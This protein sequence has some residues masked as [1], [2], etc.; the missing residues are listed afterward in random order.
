MGTRRGGPYGYPV[1][2]ETLKERRGAKAPVP[3]GRRSTALQEPNLEDLSQRSST[4]S[5][6][7]EREE[8]RVRWQLQCMTQK[9]TAHELSV[10]LARLRQEHW[11]VANVRPPPRPSPSASLLT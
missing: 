7:G 8:R 4:P 6:A 10:L 3:F 2:R 11:P 9:I 5:Q 1:R